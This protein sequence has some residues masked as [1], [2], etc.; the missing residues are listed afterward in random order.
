[1]KTQAETAARLFRTEPETLEKGSVI[2]DFELLFPNGTRQLLSQ[3]RGRCNLVII[4][5]READGRALK[6]VGELAK[7]ASALRLNEAK[8]LILGRNKPFALGDDPG[9]FASAAAPNLPKVLAGTQLIITDRFGE[10]FAAFPNANA[11]VFPSADEVVRW[12]E[13]INQQCEEC[14]PPEWQD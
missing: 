7:Q 5:V 8:V 10:I 12:L 1:M 3:F 11:S 2:P 4:F 9:I 6:S 14:S 13:F